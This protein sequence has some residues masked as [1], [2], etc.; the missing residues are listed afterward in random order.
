LKEACR[1]ILQSIR[2]GGRPRT[3]GS[4]GLRV[5]AVLERASAAMRAR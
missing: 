5:L 4:E 2:A 1:D 3:D